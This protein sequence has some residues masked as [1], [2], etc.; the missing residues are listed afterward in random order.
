MADAQILAGGVEPAPLAYTVPNAQEIILK[1]AFATFDGSAAAGA[2]LPCV[3][4]LSSGGKVVG[5]YITDSSV[6]A[7]SSAEVSFAPFLR[8][9]GGGAAATAESFAIAYRT[10]FGVPISGGAGSSDVAP[11]D[12]IDA[13]DANIDLDASGRTQILATGLYACTFALE[14]FDTTWTTPVN[15]DLETNL[16]TG[17][18]GNNIS[19]IR[20]GVHT[21]F[22]G[23]LDGTNAYN[24]Q[25]SILVYAN[26]F[27]VPEQLRWRVLNVIGAGAHTATGTGAVVSIL[28]LGDP[29]SGGVT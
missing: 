5:E 21:G 18:A 23:W 4:I 12:Y 14:I 1:A 22:P 2:F 7:G 25:L 29:S 20:P 3:R 27:T 19:T 15:I 13:N 26:I 28:R 16:V 9:A 24:T 10:G 8:N 6:A 17:G 11:W